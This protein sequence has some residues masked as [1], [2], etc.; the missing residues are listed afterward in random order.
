[1]RLLSPMTAYEGFLRAFGAPIGGCDPPQPASTNAASADAKRTMI[2]CRTL[3][4]RYQLKTTK[5]V[6][7]SAF[8][9]LPKMDVGR[10]ALDVGGAAATTA[11]A[12]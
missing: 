11:T 9:A 6:A 1:M 3:Y 2:Q 12:A 8:P 4:A 5:P 7:R 10:R